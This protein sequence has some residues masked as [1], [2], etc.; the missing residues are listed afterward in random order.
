MN[1]MQFFE[2]LQLETA[3]ARMELLSAP[4]IHRSLTGDI[5]LDDYVAFLTQAYHHVKHTV[6]L[7]MAAGGKLSE[8]KEWLREAIAE[9][10]EEELGHQEWVLNDIAA[11]GG[12]KELV[13]NS[14]PAPETELMVAYAY[15]MINR[16]NPVGFFG[17]VHVLEGTSV[18]TADTAA[19]SIQNALN[20][21]NTAFSY[22]RSHGALDQE[23]VAFFEGLMNRLE[24]ESDQAL[25]IHSARQF[26]KLYGDI[27]RSLVH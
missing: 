15:D 22:L 8:D 9:Y 16:I 20:L 1:I 25:V 18:T 6:P 14:Q 11:C 3:N 21:P 27:F 23:H 7:L 10:I 24:S 12:D 5:S 2:K 17:M 19:M 26:Y 4:I 13:R